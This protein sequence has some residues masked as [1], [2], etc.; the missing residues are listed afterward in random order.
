MS[1][2]HDKL[3]Y[4]ADI[5][6]ELSALL[7]YEHTEEEFDTLLSVRRTMLEL[8]VNYTAEAIQ[9]ESDWSM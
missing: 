8:V 9:K 5:I 3:S 7:E 2:V 4:A 1:H 6:A